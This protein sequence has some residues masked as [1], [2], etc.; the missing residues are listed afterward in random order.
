M[1]SATRATLNDQIFHPMADVA[2]AFAVAY[3]DTLRL[4]APLLEALFVHRKGIPRSQRDEGRLRTVADL[5]ASLAEQIQ[6]F[7]DDLGPVT[8]LH[9][10]E[11]PHIDALFRDI[12]A[13]TAMPSQAA[14]LGYVAGFAEVAAHVLMAKCGRTELP[15]ILAAATRSLAVRAVDVR[16]RVAALVKAQIDRTPRLAGRG[17]PTDLSLYVD[18]NDLRRP[19]DLVLDYSRPA[20]F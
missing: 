14:L 15:D 3:A 7:I 18:V 12:T 5:E 16:P 2:T 20:V 4:R 13:V 6:R 17:P 8:T 10:D 11:L 1:S 19:P 9:Q